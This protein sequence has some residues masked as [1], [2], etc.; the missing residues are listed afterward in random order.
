MFIKLWWKSTDSEVTRRANIH[1]YDV[2][3]PAIL[4]SRSKGGLAT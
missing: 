4:E 2:I 1:G 3:G